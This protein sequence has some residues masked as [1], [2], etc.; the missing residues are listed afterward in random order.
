MTINIFIRMKQITITEMLKKKDEKNVDDLVN[1][2]TILTKQLN[3]SEPVVKNEVQKHGFDWEKDI[4]INVFKTSKETLK[5]IKY[6]S[7]KDL[8]PELNSLGFTVSIKTSGDKNSVCMAD[9]LRCFESV[10][11]NKPIHLI[12][13]FFE[14]IENT[15]RLESIIEIDLTSTKEL[16]FGDLTY[17]EI[18]ELKTLL[19]NL[20]KKRS[21]TE[22]EKKPALAL[23]DSLQKKSKAIYLN[24]KWDSKSQRRLQCSFNR[25]QDFIK[26]NGSLIIE[27]NKTNELRGQKIQLELLSSQRSF[28]SK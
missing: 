9:C 2:L 12:V 10:S 18:E 15:K 19:K 17:E 22:E 21:L 24:I 28:K 16:L 8:P 14:Q 6:T 25:F 23:R 13:V 26:E 1:E 3:I 4:L 11:D 5:E 20:P 7:P 27:H